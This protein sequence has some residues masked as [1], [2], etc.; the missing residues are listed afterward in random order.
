MRPSLPG[1]QVPGRWHAKEAGREQGRRT[2]QARGRPRGGGAGVQRKGRSGGA[3][4]W[5]G[6]KA[7]LA[8]LTAQDAAAH[9]RAG[10]AGVRGAH[11]HV[12]AA[13]GAADAGGDGRGSTGGA[14]IATDD[15]TAG[16]AD[17]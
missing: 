1:A 9:P 8:L 2:L 10:A 13:G 17:A 16:A 7:T 5:L 12:A 11:H 4:A 14:E 15:A 3:R 6:R